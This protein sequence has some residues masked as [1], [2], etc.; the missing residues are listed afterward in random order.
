MFHTR[1]RASLAAALLA[2]TF[3][4][5]LNFVEASPCN[6]FQ[7]GEFQVNSF[8]ADSQSVPSVAMDADGD[9]VVAWESEYQDGS[10][11]GIFAQRF[12]AAGIARGPEFQVNSYTASRQGRPS[13]AMDADGNFVVAWESWGQDGDNAGV[14][15]Q[16]YDAAGVAQGPEFLVNTNTTSIQRRPAVAM[17]ADGD[18]VVAWQ[19]Y[20][21]P[22]PEFDIFAQRFNAAGATQGP[23]FRVN[24]HIPNSQ[25]S[26]TVAMDADGDFVVAWE[27]YFQGG[28]E[29][30]IFAQRF[31]TAGVA[32]GGEFEVS[33]NDMYWQYSAS[34]ALDADGDFVVAWQHT[35]DEGPGTYVGNVF[36][37]RY[38]AAGVA[39]GPEFLVNTYT[40]D[41]QAFPSVAMDAD[42]NFVVAWT[43]EDQ[44]GSRGGIFAQRYNA[45]GVA[46][47]PE[48]QVNTYTPLDQTLPSV[49]MDADGDFVTA[50]MSDRQDGSDWGIFAQRYDSE[51]Q[52]PL[53]GQASI[54]SDWQ[55]I[56]LPGDVM[57]PVVIVGPPT[58]HGA[59]PGVVRLRGVTSDGFEASFQE[60]T[61]LDG[62]HAT[63]DIPYLALQAGRHTMADGSIWEVGSFPLGGTRAWQAELFAQ[64]FDAAPALF[65]TAQTS[66]GSQPVAV[67]ARNVTA[68]GFEAALFEEEALMDGH[69]VE[70]VG[71]LA[72]FSPKGSGSVSLGSLTMADVTAPYLIQSPSVDHRFTPVLS[73]ALK[74]EEETSQD[75]ETVHAAET[76]SVLALGGLLFAQ[77]VSARGSDT[78]ALR[79]LAPE[80]DTPMEWGAV[81]GIT[82]GWSTVPLCR[83]YKNPVVVAKPVSARGGDA[84]V[85]RTRDVTE[86]AFDLSYQEWLDLDGEH[87]EER[88]FYLAAEAGTHD[89]AGLTVEAGTLET[90]K[91]L[92]GGWETVDLSAAFP[93]VPAVFTGVMSFNGPDPVTTRVDDVT[94]VDFLVT[95]TEEEAKADGHNTETL[96]WIAVEQGNGTTDDGRAVAVSGAQATDVPATVPL[97]IAADRMFPVIVGDVTSTN[98][99]DPVFLRQ[100]NLTPTSVQLY[101]QEEQ[102][103]DS[104]TAHAPED[105]SIFVAE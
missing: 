28:S 14:F 49:A 50:W 77:D 60:W 62:A 4:T 35:S 65:L 46:Q 63:E 71:Y 22:G 69:S 54:S 40:T 58:L 26:P 101:L 76:L 82:D 70:D 12:D 98:E 68:S 55:S 30:S 99:I 45:A 53:W 97:G 88:V 52:R 37:Q 67:R 87:T 42:G 78:V 91:L 39:Q 19:S 20:S 36:A 10:D 24:T 85:I 15:A 29:V 18:F 89:L 21:E 48:F 17:D 38:N 90:K 7:E 74:L 105:V 27:S 95:M 2:A 44:D 8:V 61:Y 83:Q 5:P 57:D 79:R 81:A 41:N 11:L 16:R 6:V 33:T 103:L 94:G 66:R 86:N 9:F 93:G 92:Y 47:G 96:G 72:V 102:S 31:D 73:S 80:F 25:F 56:T 64:P 1:K 75:L 23:E 32:Q 51:G 43:S 59:A 3:L 34:V 13:V 104:E 100:R 84:G